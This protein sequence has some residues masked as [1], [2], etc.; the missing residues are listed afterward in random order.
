MRARPGGTGRTRPTA[1]IRAPGDGP[2]SLLA[3]D[4]AV[5]DGLSGGQRAA[6]ARVF[7]DLI[8]LTAG[9]LGQPEVQRVEHAGHLLLAG[10]ERGHRAAEMQ[11]RLGEDEGGVRV[12]GPARTGDEHAKG[13]TGDLAAHAGVYWHPEHVEDAHDGE[14]G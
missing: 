11:L 14:D 12:T 4:E 8:H 6:A 1:D 3:L 2:G 10:A 5:S 7:A 9:D 13:G